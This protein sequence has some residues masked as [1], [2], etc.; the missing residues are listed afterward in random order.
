MKTLME[1]DIEVS[2]LTHLCIL[3]LCNILPSNVKVN[4]EIIYFRN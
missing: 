4:I 1:K 2:K 3:E